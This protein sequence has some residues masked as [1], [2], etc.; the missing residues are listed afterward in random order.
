MALGYAILI[1]S[2]AVLDYGRASGPALGANA[3][4]GTRSSGQG[5]GK[6]AGPRTLC[7]QGVGMSCMG[8]VVCTW[9]VQD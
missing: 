2:E 4:S 7:T 1:A 8:K 5:G 6:M 3:D 9:P